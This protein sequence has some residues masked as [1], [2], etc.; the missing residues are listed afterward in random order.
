M[1]IKV[2]TPPAESITLEEARLQ[3]KVD[4]DDTTH[5]ALLASL[6]TMAREFAEHYTQRSIGSQTLELALDEFPAGDGGIELRQGP[7]ASIT[8]VSYTDTAGDPQTMDTSA[9]LLDNY[10]SPAWLLP[11]YG[12]TW[13]STLDT[14]NAVKVR[15]VA[16]DLKQAVKNAML[17]HIEIECPLNPLTPA[18][19]ESM[20]RARD[21]L[22]NTVKVWGF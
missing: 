20:E 9:Y 8:S 11:L 6:I 13:P 1:P 4:S 15:Y 7:V 14:A 5:D 3:C 2:I 21:S 17:L 18:E 22:L 12:T 16:G 19:R 10:S